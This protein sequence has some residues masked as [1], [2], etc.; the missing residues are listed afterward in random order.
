RDGK[1]LY[2]SNDGSNSIS[3]IDTASGRL[4]REIETGD[5]PAR[6]EFTPDEK[7]LVYNLQRGEG[8]GFADPATG[9]E[10]ARVKLPG[11]PLSLS[12]SRDGRTAYLGLMDSDSVAIVS[13]PERKLIRVIP[14]PKGAGPD[15]V[16]PLL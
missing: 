6:A 11:K 5:E 8:C 1:R 13:V 4:V 9:K 7:L 2:V 10:I 12:L 14:T 16:T 15:T 3:V